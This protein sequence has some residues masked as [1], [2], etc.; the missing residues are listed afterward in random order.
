M[1]GTGEGLGKRR[2]LPRKGNPEGSRMYTGTAPR[3]RDHQVH[4]L[5]SQRARREVKGSLREERAGELGK[6]CRLE[7][8][9]RKCVLD[10]Q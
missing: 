10:R 7:D 4:F 3:C 2:F 9:K 1:P 6:C 5:W 8:S